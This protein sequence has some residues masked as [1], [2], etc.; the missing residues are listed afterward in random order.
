[1]SVIFLWYFREAPGSNHN[2]LQGSVT[3]HLSRFFLVT[4]TC[5]FPL[6]LTGQDY[7]YPFQNPELTIEE[8]VDDLVSRLSLEEKVG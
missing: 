6:L 3:M 4:F 7:D 5:L 2:I 1:M 8:R